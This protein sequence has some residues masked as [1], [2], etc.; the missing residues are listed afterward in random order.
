MSKHAAT[1]SSRPSSSSPTQ[2]TV[3]IST[4]ISPRR[5]TGCSLKR[6]CIGSGPVASATGR[7]CIKR[8]FAD[9]AAGDVAAG[10]PLARREVD[11]V[12]GCGLMSLRPALAPGSP[13]LSGGPNAEERRQEETEVQELRGQGHTQEGRQSGAVPALRRDRDQAVSRVRH[14][15]RQVQN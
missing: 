15:H 12:G 9:V 8:C 11:R 4:T 5:I 7:A 3:G 10:C 2:G 6:F 13:V 1:Q 14:M